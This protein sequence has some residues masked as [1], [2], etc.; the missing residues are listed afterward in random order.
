MSPRLRIGYSVPLEQ[1]P[2]AEVLDLAVHAARH[3][4]D[5]VMAADQFQPWT[6]RQG[7][8]PFVWNML[9]ALAERT[10]GEIGLGATAPTFRWHP[11]TV[12]Q[13]SATL[14]AMYPDR[15]WL[16]IGSGEAINEHIVGEYWPE[17]PE[18]IARMFEAVDVIKKLF[19]SGLAGKDVKHAGPHF[20]LESTRLWTMPPTAPEILIATGGPVTARRAGKTADGLITIGA[21]VEKLRTLLTRFAEGAREAGKDPATMPK[22]LQLAVSWAPTD[23]EATRNALTEW[24]IGGLRAGRSDIRS[25]HEFEQLGRMVRA[26]DFEGR[27]LV[28]SDLDAHRA[29]LRQFAALGFDRIMVRNVGRNQR[30]WIETFGRAVLPAVLA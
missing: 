7:Q 25:P 2:P 3:G 18:R 24:P 23:D 20:R 4:F 9:T 26:E 1:F 22:V 5:G 12:A 29:H 17:A 10:E 8:A 27:L 11:A 14:A 28:S 21:P 30:E 15:H 6:P 16:G 19:A 13:A